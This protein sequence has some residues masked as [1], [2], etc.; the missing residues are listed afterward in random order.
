MKIPSLHLTRSTIALSIKAFAVLL[1]S[2]AIFYQDLTIVVNEAL[3]SEMLSY[4]IAIP[5]LFVYVL[6]RKTKMVR[7][8][9]PLESADRPKE[10]R[11]LA[12]IAGILISTIAILLYWYGS[13]TFTPLEF[14][15]F[16][17]PIF[18]TGCTLI[19]FNT[20][21]LRQLSFPILFLFFLT[22][23]PLEIVYQAGAALS[24]FSSQ[25]TYNILK[26]LGLPVSLTIQ[27]G[28]PT[29][30]LQK[31]G[32]QLTF[33]IDIACSSIYSIMGFLIF[34]VFTTYIARSSL[35]KKATIFFIGFPLIYVLNILR[36]TTIVLVGN[37]SGMEL[38][39][40]TFHLLGGWSLIFLGT[41]LL[42]VISEKLFKIQLFTA[43]FKPTSCNRCNQNQQNKQHFCPACGKLLKPLDIKLSK[44]D[45]SKIAI[46]TITAILIINLQVPVFALKK[47]PAEVTI[48][49]LGGEQTVTQILPEISGYGTEFIY[50]DKRFEEIAQQDASLTYAYIPT[51]NSGA[52]IWVTIEIAETKSSLHGWVFCLITWPQIQGR[53]LQVTQ[54][55]L[56]D[57]QLLENPPIT[58]RYFA[59]QDIKT[60]RT[61][62]TLYW[63]ENAIFNTGSNL[64][65]KHVE[66][67]LIS[68]T[69]SPENI[70]TIEDQLLPFGKAI[71][72]YWQSIKTWSQITLTISQ[73]GAPLII[74]TTTLL[75]ITLTFQA[76][77]K[78]KE[79]KANMEAYNKLALKE[80]KLILQA[81]HQAAK[82]GTATGIAVASSY[83]KLA[84]KT[85]DLNLLLEKLDEAHQAGLIE[86]E[87][88]NR[89]DEPLVTWKTQVLFPKPSTTRKIISSILH[90]PL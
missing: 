49:T 81:V 89:E 90:K 80:E 56:R 57:V 62:V 14:H 66:I 31:T 5:F 63:Y 32:G 68:F 61:Q 71:A 23:P 65:Q 12:T 45:L 50:R 38:A 88:A 39:L 20:Q 27:Y 25:S 70:P 29:I 41:L 76:I 3:K 34:A 9:V 10:T 24:N 16:A 42:L 78:L 40:Q 82:E 74:I 35:W 72:N 18:V 11:H 1:A 4:I 7:A 17:L 55:S 87:I 33:A 8:V 85:I 22:P 67:S 54:L 73:N 64:E 52:T 47:G 79:K 30:I 69:N 77:K 43:K 84:G 21:T 53:E 26:T 2:I 44:R 36:I 86:K 75:A 46:L 83:H 48:Q 59:F 13:Y 37:Y 51:S 19:M 28:T 60:N 58:A 15:M 6:Y